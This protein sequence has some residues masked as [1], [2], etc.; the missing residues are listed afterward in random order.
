MALCAEAGTG[1]GPIAPRGWT[2][3]PLGSAT[4]S[5]GFPRSDQGSIGPGNLY[6]DPGSP[7]PVDSMDGLG[8]RYGSDSN[9]NDSSGTAEPYRG[10]DHTPSVQGGNWDGSLFPDGPSQRSFRGRIPTPS[11]RGSQASGSLNERDLNSSRSR[12]RTPTPFAPTSE[13]STI[14]VRPRAS[15]ARLPP[16]PCPAPRAH[17][18]TRSRYTLRIP[19]SRSPSVS[20]V[21]DVDEWDR[22]ENSSATSSSVGR[23]RSIEL[24]DDLL[25]LN[26]VSLF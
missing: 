8:L 22:V 4:S 21:E 10:R 3:V 9:S 24:P 23:D 12:A 2:P 16:S 18:D 6:F 1:I 19:P 17:R 5:I 15:T 14:T 20:S 13:R 25:D 7:V 11:D 26:R